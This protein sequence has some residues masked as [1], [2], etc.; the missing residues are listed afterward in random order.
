MV[1]TIKDGC[2]QTVQSSC[3]YLKFD[4]LMINVTYNYLEICSVLL[5]AGMIPLIKNARWL[6]PFIMTSRNREQLNNIYEKYPFVL[7]EIVVEN[8]VLLLRINCLLIQTEHTKSEQ[9]LELDQIISMII[10]LREKKLKVLESS[11]WKVVS[12][13]VRL[14]LVIT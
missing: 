3:F 10:I 7:K 8:P 9:N 5:L 11:G 4:S 12:I 14:N 6:L 1:E 2:H 13:Y